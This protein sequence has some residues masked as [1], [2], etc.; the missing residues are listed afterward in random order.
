MVSGRNRALVCIF[1]GFA[2][3]LGLT[4]WVYRADAPLPASAAATDFSALR[5]RPLL[6]ELV[7]T[8]VPHPLGSSAN[9][10]VRDVIV[11]RLWALGYAT[12]TQT[13][14]ACGRYGSCGLPTN[15]V[16]RLKGAD[17]GD[18][19]LLAAHYDSVAAG[20]G[21]SDDAVNVAALLEIARIMTVAPPT[22][23]P[24]ILLITDGEEAGLLGAELFV[25]EHPLAARVKAAVNLEARGVSGPSL[26]FETGNAVGWSMQLYARAVGHPITNSA[27]YVAYKALHN[28]TDFSVFKQA[29]YQGFNFAF[30]D[31]VAQYH[32]PQDDFAG[33]SLRSLQQQGG[34]ALAALRVLA[35]AADLRP[36]GSDAVW[37]DVFARLLIRWPAAACMPAALLLAGTLAA[38]VLVLLMKRTVSPSQWLWGTLAALTHLVAGTAAITVVV[39]LLV[40]IGRFPSLGS[41]PWLAHPL[42]MTVACIAAAVA[43]AATVSLW[44]TKHTG[45]WGQW[46]GGATLCG[47][48]VLLV[49]AAAPGASFAPAVAALATLLAVLPAVGAQLRR[50]GGHDAAG[51]PQGWRTDVACVSP[52][53]LTMAVLAPMIYLLYPAVGWPAWPID[54]LLMSFAALMLL[55]PLAAATRLSRLRLLTTAGALVAGG[56][57]LTLAAPTYSAAVPLRLNLCYWLNADRRSADWVAMSGSGRL[58]HRLAQA[59]AFERRPRRM[60]ED[61]DLD[62]FHAA[63][64]VRELAAPQLALEQATVQSTPQGRRTHYVLHLRSAR[65][66]PRAFVAFPAAA[67]VHA[68]EMQGS[69]GTLLVPLWTE[70]SGASRF[71]IA[72]L[73]VA[74]VDFS[75]DAATDAAVSIEVFDVS[76]GLG[77]GEFLQR[78]R[79]S[80]ATRSQDGD[81]TVVQHTV[82]LEPASRR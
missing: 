67:G 69:G 32:T 65:G 68:V 11:S 5:A 36:R 42:P 1:L 46:A 14:W 15:I 26:M 71:D 16:A 33:V 59:A 2:L 30:V 40:L 4:L 24:I 10:R 8:D 49:S 34:N 9:A 56:T 58:P 64:P 21:A 17:S 77:D 82:S 54:T 6:Q 28:D 80:D 44:F 25:R 20:P 12:E 38:T 37:F 75:F 52:A 74:G 79:P 39:L 3:L 62:G 48:L 55:P 78:A 66:A 76:Y 70:S 41:G 7:G 57:L 72:S 63:A 45:F 29:G 60:Y 13:G 50:R 81:I 19:V 73:P 35:D 23:H 51:S 47:V 18:A 61:A 53:L 22:R 27:F 31:G 43:G